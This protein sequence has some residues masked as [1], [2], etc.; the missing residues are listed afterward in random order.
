M[1]SLIALALSA[2]LACKGKAA[3]EAL[4]TND[5]L[6]RRVMVLGD[7]I[8]QQ[9]TWVSFLQYY[10]LRDHPGAKVD[11]IGIGLASETASG[12][13]EADHPFPRPCIH[14]RLERALETI[15]PEIVIACYGMNDGIYH[16]SSPERDE[17][18]HR[19]MLKLIHTCKARGAGKILLMTPGTFGGNR[20]SDQPPY[21][22]KTPFSGYDGVLAGY[23]AWLMNLKEPGVMT[24]DLHTPMR[25]HED[26]RR[27][28]DSAFRLAGDGIHPGPLGHLIMA[29]AAM[30]ALGAPLP[31]DFQKE[32]AAVSADPLYQLVDRY[33]RTRSDGWLPYVGYTRDKTVKTESVDSTE[34]TCAEI[35]VRIDGIRRK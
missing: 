11:I 4:T 14:E 7:S 21:G 3:D 35:M 6:N 23:A 30:N 18:F 29:R 31:E 26:E 34:K 15:R 32:L 22:F 2:I 27:K 8:T 1:R 13:S 12:L 33:R 9:G 20:T 5:L 25:R 10:L 28:T 16:P 17:A 24:A 19:G